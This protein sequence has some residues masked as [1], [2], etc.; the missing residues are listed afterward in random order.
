VIP[1]PALKRHN[2][3]WAYLT[4]ILALAQVTPLGKFFY[5]WRCN[6]SAQRFC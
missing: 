6:P 5:G 4:S 3:A 1:F 2:K